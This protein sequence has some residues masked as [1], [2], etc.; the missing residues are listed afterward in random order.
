MYDIN[1]EIISKEDIDVEGAYLKLK[2]N[3]SIF[4]RHNS[5]G[6]IGYRFSFPNGYKDETCF[7]GEQNGKDTVYTEVSCSTGWHDSKITSSNNI[8]IFEI[9]KSDKT[10]VLLRRQE[11]VISDLSLPIINFKTENMNDYIKLNINVDNY[12]ETKMKIK[13]YY[14]NL[15]EIQI[16]NNTTLNFYVNTTV[17][18]NVYNENDEVISSK[19]IT[20]IVDYSQLSNTSIDDVNNI[21]DYFKDISQVNINLMQ[22][23]NNFW[24]SLKNSSLFV[25]I[26]ISFIGTILL[27]IISIIKR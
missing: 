4:I 5:V 19:Y 14:D 3:Y 2:N 12:D 10:T 15:N 23:F 1:G 20:V 16:S 8:L 25:P 27:L 21:M 9:R 11:N 26:I 7:F 24:V 6:N 18:V 22:Q 17:Y 13:Y